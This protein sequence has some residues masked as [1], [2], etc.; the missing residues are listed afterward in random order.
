MEEPVE[1]PS[2]FRSPE[3]NL[4]MDAEFGEIPLLGST[5]CVPTYGV[6]GGELD[7]DLISVLKWEGF[8]DVV[9]EV[10]GLLRSCGV[11]SKYGFGC[12]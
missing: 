6:L 4:Q 3:C 12:L 10:D 9:G 2:F 8:E 7:A 5:P 1:G 11:R